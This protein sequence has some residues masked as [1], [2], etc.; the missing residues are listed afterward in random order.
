MTSRRRDERRRDR[1]PRCGPVAICRVGASAARPARR[2][3]RS[4]PSRTS[5][6]AYGGAD[7]ARRRHADD[8]AG[9][10][11]LPARPFRLRQ[12]DAAAGRRR[13]RDADAGRVLIDGREVAGPELLRAAGAARHR[14]DV[15]GLR[16]VSRTSTILENVHVRPDARSPRAR[17]TIAAAARA[18]RASGSSATPTT[19]P[20][21]LSG[22][23]QQRVALAALDRAAARRAPDGRA[24]LQ[25]RPAHAR[26]D[27]RRDRGD[28]AR[29]RRHHHRRHARSRGGDAD[30]R[31]DRA[32]AG[33]AH[34][35]GRA[36]R[37][38]LPRPGR[39]LRR[40]L[41]LR[42]QRGRGRGRGRAGRDARSGCLPAPQAAGRRRAVVCIRPQGVRLKPAGFCLPGRVLSRRFLGEVDLVE[43]A[44]QGLDRPLQARVR[45]PV[46]R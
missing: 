31:P 13:R 45:E 3:R 42:F 12:D 16:A 20:H 2:S 5:C 29:D 26:R 37:G 41:L 21:I 32:D 35:A 33:R 28:P 30:R 15:P 39:P 6:Q 34:H 9:R 23:E 4:S 14:P 24:V 18:C 25:S 19:I 44:V 46:A 43:I 38:A 40:A 8:R 36:G 22:G 1:R 27:P 11:R 10:D 7:R 17:P